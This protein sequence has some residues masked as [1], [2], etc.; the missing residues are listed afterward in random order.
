[1]RSFPAGKPVPA[2]SQSPLPPPS[3][4]VPTKTGRVRIRFLLLTQR[5][6]GIP[7][8]D[9]LEPVAVV[10][11]VPHLVHHIDGVSAVRIDRLIQ[12]NRVHHRLQRQYDLLLL[13]SIRWA[14]CSMVGS[15][16]N[17]WMNCSLVCIA[18]VCRIPHRAADLY[19]IVVRK[20]RRISPT[21]IGTP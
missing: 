19:R 14:I 6:D 18:S 4:S 13:H 3:G 7:Q 5:A 20:G 1:M 9:L 21:I 10:A 8:A 16:P 17:S 12:R 2:K 11:A 15:L